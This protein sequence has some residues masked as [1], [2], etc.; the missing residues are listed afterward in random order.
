[1]AE[2]VAKESESDDVKIS[3]QWAI[4]LTVF[5]CTLVTVGMPSCTYQETIRATMAEMTDWQYSFGL[6]LAASFVAQDTLDWASCVFIALFWFGV[7][8]WERHHAK[9]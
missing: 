4:A 7:A 3:R 9:R 6:F 1:M 5:L 2:Q 8:V